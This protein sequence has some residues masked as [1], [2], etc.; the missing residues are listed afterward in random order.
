MSSP[1]L[2]SRLPQQAQAEGAGITTRSRGRCS[3]KGTRRRRR[4]VCLPLA[5]WALPAAVLRLGRVLARSSDEFAE[6]Q[7]E[8]V[9]QL[10]AALGRGAEAVMLELGDQ[11]LEMRHH[12]LGWPAPM[13]WS[14][15]KLNASS[16]CPRRPG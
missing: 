10:A 13:R 11:Q 2:E 12:R 1:S 7:L 9:D 14:G 15:V 6:F 8:L 16:A 5:G 3:G 4:R